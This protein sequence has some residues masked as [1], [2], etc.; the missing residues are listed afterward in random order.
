MTDDTQLSQE[1][2]VGDRFEWQVQSADAYKEV[3]IVERLE[4]GVVGG[5]CV[6][7]GPRSI[8]P[9]SASWPLRGFE[10]DV[11]AGFWRRLPR[12]DKPTL[13]RVCKDWGELKSGMRVALVTTMGGVVEFGLDKITIR[14][15]DI[16][17]WISSCGA[18]GFSSAPVVEG[19]V[20]ILSEPPV[21]TK[22]EADWHSKIP[23]GSRW[24]PRDGGTKSYILVVTGYFDHLVQFRH[25]KKDHDCGRLAHDLF[26]EQY[27][28]I[29]DW[30]EHLEREREIEGKMRN[31]L[32]YDSAALMKAD[33]RRS[34]QDWLASGGSSELS[35]T[36][37]GAIACRM[38]GLVGVRRR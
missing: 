38:A 6:S 30:A 2:R 20:T 34:A 11:A 27:V 26:L 13:P 19:R 28:R 35:L 15:D 29:D 17:R 18:F 8:G 12:E 1:I 24:T 21:E 25:D 16:P 33:D 10:N 9:R 3:W 22:R 36:G 4:D 23:I 32:Q 14:T 7:G 5:R 37:A 31:C